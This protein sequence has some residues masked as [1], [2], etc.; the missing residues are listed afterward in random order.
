[1]YI[2]LPPFLFSLLPNINMETNND[3]NF[4]FLII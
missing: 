4:A 2:F 3:S 1:M